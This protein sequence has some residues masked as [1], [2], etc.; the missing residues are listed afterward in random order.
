MKRLT[1]FHKIVFAINTVFVF[2]LLIACAVPYISSEKFS[3]LS[4]LSLAVP[5]LVGSNFIFLVYWIIRKK[6]QLWL[7]LFV[8]VFSYFVLGTFV[9][10]TFSEEKI[11]EEDLSVM[12]YNVRSFNK[13]GGLNN[14]RVFE[15]V[16][17]LIDK[18]DPDIICFQE[19]GYLRRKEYTKYPYKFLKYI[20]NPGKVLLAIFSKYP[21]IKA[22][23]IH[24]PKTANNGSYADILYMNDTIR[25][26][27]IHLESF[28]ITPNPNVL[29]KEPTGKLFKRLEKSF[30]M[31]Q[32]QAK[33]ID[34]HCKSTPYK[35]IICGDFNNTQFSNVYQTIKGDM[36]D[37]FLAKGNGYGKTFNFLSIPLRIDFILAD[38]AFEVKRHKNYNEKL[39]DHFPIMASFSM[40]SE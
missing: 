39:S 5:F 20:N 28:K 9:K 34:L 38:E 15:D 25:I 7:S 40:K 32:Q 24:F 30:Q 21:I 27:N 6:R 26:Y 16:K 37:T 1:L 35:K 11:L 13:N 19:T 22:E 29:Q 23:L 18:E 33:I 12:S 17:K 3:F 31:Q 10:L 36:Q 8:L 2:L 14:P 4:F